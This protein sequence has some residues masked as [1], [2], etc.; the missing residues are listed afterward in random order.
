MTI[1]EFRTNPLFTA[2]MRE[3]L[4][5]E[6]MQRALLV[7]RDTNL[8]QDL[9]VG[10]DPV[11][12]VRVHS[13]SVGYNAA[14]ADLLSLADPPQTPPAELEADYASENPQP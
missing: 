9:P 5:D 3:I 1:S 13:K 12:S 10:C 11:A 2:K 8:P 4:S 6:I 14:I 7:I